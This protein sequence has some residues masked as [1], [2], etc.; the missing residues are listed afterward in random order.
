MVYLVPLPGL[1]IVCA[2]AVEDARSRRVPR[3]GVLA[4]VIIQLIALLVFC[5]VGDQ[6]LWPIILALAV[7]LSATLVQTALAVAKPGSLGLGDVTATAVAGLSLGLLGWRTAL[8][9]WVL[10]GAIGLLA[11]AIHTRRQAGRIPRGGHGTDPGIPFVTVIAA[12][13]LLADAAAWYWSL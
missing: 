13:A 10:M 11:L 3:L 9:W 4:G 1:F 2:L 6:G 12:A 7:G 5:A 8:V